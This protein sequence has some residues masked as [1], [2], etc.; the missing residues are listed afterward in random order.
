M[1]LENVFGL[2]FICHDESVDGLNYFLC[3]YIACG[4]VNSL[5]SLTVDVVVGVFL[6]CG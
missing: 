2:T 4:A 5:M 3:G 6:S 1:Q